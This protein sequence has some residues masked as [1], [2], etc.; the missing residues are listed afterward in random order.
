MSSICL[1][2]WEF[3][4]LFCQL[5]KKWKAETGKELNKKEDW[6]TIIGKPERKRNFK[7]LSEQIGIKL[8][9]SA[10]VMKSR[11]LGPGYFYN[12]LIKIYEGENPDTEI[13]LKEEDVL[14]LIE[15]LGCKTYKSYR[16]K[17]F[18]INDYTGMY[19]SQTY[20]EVRTFE[21][22]IVVPR[23]EEELF[24]PAR[25][26]VESRGFHDNIPDSVLR[27]PLEP[28]KECW[29]S[30]LKHGT[31]YLQLSIYMRAEINDIEQVTGVNQLFGTIATISKR[32]HLINVECVLAK[33][34]VPAAAQQGI[35]RYLYLRR[36]YF[37]VYTT[38]EDQASIA[39]VETGGVSIRDI[40]WL[41]GKTFRILAQGPN[42]LFMQSRFHIQKNYT[43]WIKVPKV[44]H[45]RSLACE[46]FVDKLPANPLLV[47]SYLDEKRKVI[48]TVTTIKF[49]PKYKKGQVL[50][51]AYFIMASSY[52]DLAGYN[53]VLVE[54][55]SKFGLE[56]Y[57]EEATKK[58]SGQDIRKKLLDELKKKP[59]KKFKKK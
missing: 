6:R 33:K 58:W 40:G 13:T 18:K 36:N 41:A 42:G 35:E 55:A 5:Y 11:K 8:G 19:Y 59:S 50:R 49:E 28:Y 4:L 39:G 45:G 34:S 1:T 47:Y 48:Y 15:Y 2:H 31:Y 56:L 21:L 32:H 51:G 52:N 38:D 7:I 43:A 29:L 57:S 24:F 27:G 54:D 12:R 9:I 17:H 37:G 25:A 44:E 16:E 46:L 14:T 53:F 3:E 20:H 22:S 23:W 26:W 10:A 30:L